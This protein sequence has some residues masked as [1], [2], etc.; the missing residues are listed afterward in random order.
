MTTFTYTGGSIGP[1]LLSVP[2]SGSVNKPVG[3]PYRFYPAAT[4]VVR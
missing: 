2:N 4:P 3:E 1:S